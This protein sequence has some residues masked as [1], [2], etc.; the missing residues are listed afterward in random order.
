M[1]TAEAIRTSG[2]PG[3]NNRPSVRSVGEVAAQRIPYQRQERKLIV[4]DE[5]RLE[6]AGAI[7]SL[8][9]LDKLA[10]GINNPT[11]PFNPQ[12]KEH[13]ID[14]AHISQHVDQALNS[15][16]SKATDAAWSEEQVK[17]TVDER[18]NRKIKEAE[19]NQVRQLNKAEREYITYQVQV[20]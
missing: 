17:Q 6:I 4:N 9:A 1:P 10:R 7:N 5:T 3:I 20:E 19:R 16:W 2:S 12:D 11:A 18:A 8:N 13:P 14:T 15:Q